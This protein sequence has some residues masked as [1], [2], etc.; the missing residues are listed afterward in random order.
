MENT[1]NIMT[2]LSGCADC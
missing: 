2:R 1:W